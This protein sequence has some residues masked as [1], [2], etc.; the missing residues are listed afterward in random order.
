[1][2]TSNF[3]CLRCDMCVRCKHT[4]TQTHVADHDL[5]RDGIGH[6]YANNVLHNEINL[7]RNVLHS[8]HVTCMCFDF[9]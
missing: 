3:C 2:K 5:C 8:V 9:C 4:L 1:M 6:M 7:S